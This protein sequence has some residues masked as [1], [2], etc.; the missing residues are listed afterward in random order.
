MKIRDVILE[1]LKEELLLFRDTDRYRAIAATRLIAF[2]IVT[3][4]GVGIWQIQLGKVQF[5]ISFVLSVFAIFISWLFFWAAD[6]SA[7]RQS[8]ELKSFIEEFRKATDRRFDSLE[9]KYELTSVTKDESK[10]LMSVPTTNPPSN[11]AKLVSASLKVEAKQLMIALAQYA[12]GYS[13][14][15]RIDYGFETPETKSRGFTAMSALRRQL[16]QLGLVEFD[17]KNDMITI[18]PTGMEFVRWLEENGEK[19]TFFES[20]QLGGWGT[21]SEAYLKFRDESKKVG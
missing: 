13:E 16:A 3:V 2:V 10:P 19:A 8:R 20:S 11:F 14:Y 6:R 1:F 17:P 15:A 21:P 18:S 7:E 9:Q 4:I 5:D 12:K